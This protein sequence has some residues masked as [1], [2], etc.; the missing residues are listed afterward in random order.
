MEVEVERQKGR[1][2]GSIIYMCSIKNR[3]RKL[4]EEYEL[5]GYWLESSVF[6]ISLVLQSA[7]ASPCRVRK[8]A[9]IRRWCNWISGI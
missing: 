4:M 3:N 6:L 7:A 1:E 5:V 2:G 8:A 9:F